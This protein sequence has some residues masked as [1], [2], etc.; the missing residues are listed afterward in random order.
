LLLSDVPAE[1]SNRQ[2]PGFFPRWHSSRGVNT[3]ITSHHHLVSRL[4]T[5]G[6]MSPLLKCLRMVRLN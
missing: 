2:A 5:R 4:N 3:C 1:A 6:A